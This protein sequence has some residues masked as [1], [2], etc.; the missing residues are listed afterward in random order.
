MSN[1]IIIPTANK[2]IKLIDE[3]HQCKVEAINDFEIKVSCTLGLLE[4]AKILNVN[5]EDVI[6]HKIGYWVLEDGDK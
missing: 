6:N 2:P 3:S 1:I 5:I 4:I